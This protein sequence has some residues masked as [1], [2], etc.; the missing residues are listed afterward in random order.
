MTRR[1]LTGKILYYGPEGE[2]GREWFESVAHPGGRTLRAF[3]EM[4]EIA[5]TR[6]A[7]Y[8]LDEA[9]RPIDAFARVVKDGKVLGTTLFL[10]DDGAVECEGLIAGMGRISQRNPTPGR[11]S[12]LGL[13]PLVGDALVALSRGTERKG[14]FETVT[15][16]ANSLAPDGDEGLYAM[17]TAI[18]VAYMGEEDIAVP[19]GR[20]PA[21]RYALRW[22][23]A[24]EP[25]DLWVTGEEAIFVKL[26][27]AMIGARY[28][29]VELRE[30]R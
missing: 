21:R 26:E 17:P 5:L 4:D 7:S 28:E 1:F 6:D 20:F 8:A 23:P 24:W 9:G 27:W 10:V 12:Y 3:C 25:A 11:T 13:H 18:A 2:N 19:A 14:L 30:T 22:N 29:L 16:I 15:G